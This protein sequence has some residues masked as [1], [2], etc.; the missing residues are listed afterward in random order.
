MRVKEEFLNLKE[1]NLYPLLMF[2]L[3]RIKDIPEYMEI[4]RLSFILEKE[5]LLKL[6]KFFGG[7]TISIPTLE[8]LERTLSILLLYE[9]VNI[10]KMDFIEACN[11]IGISE[12]I[13]V[14]KTEYTKVCDIL[15]K[16]DFN[17][18]KQ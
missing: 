16:Y 9:Y 11:L 8:E 3:Y 7:M 13:R 12:D 17:T 10:E 1:V 5:D 14:I 18:V 6:C 2:A 15:N 4:S